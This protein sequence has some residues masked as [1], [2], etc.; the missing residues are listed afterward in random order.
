MSTCQIP[1]SEFAADVVEGLSRRENKRLAPKYFYDDLGSA[2]FEAITLLPE[3]GLTRADERLL[4]AHAPDVARQVGRLSAVAELGSG[5]GKKSLHVLR[6]QKERNPDLVYHPIDVSGAALAV[7]EREIGDLC[8]VS[9]ICSDWMAGLQQLSDQRTAAS[10]PMLLLFLGSS[11]GNLERDS[12]PDFF[13]TVRSHLRAGDYLLMGA[14][15]VK[16]LERMIDAYD[17]PT[18]VTSAFNLNL[19]G[20]INREFDASFDL[21]GFAHE[22]RWNEKHRRIEM[23]LLACRNQEVCCRALDTTFSFRAGETIWTESSHK[24]LEQELVDL[25]LNA[26]FEPVASWVD[27]EWPLA[28]VLWR[29]SA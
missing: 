15:L 26:G 2:L 29:V 10:D 3:Y 5:S 18:G 11:V 24:F 20:R 1:V 4:A 25:A 8:Q 28:E 22:V 9:S 16:D 13:R 17:D 14:D 7:C 6:A 23:H 21:S 19:L 27:S 12:L